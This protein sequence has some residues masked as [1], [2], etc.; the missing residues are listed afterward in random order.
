MNAV[1]AKPAKPIE[2]IRAQLNLPKMREQLQ[3]PLPRQVDL[4][5]FLRVAITAI[6]QNPDLLKQDRSSLYA[7]IMT[8]AQLGLLPDVQLGECYFIPR[9]GKVC[10]DPGYRGLIK[11]ARQGDIGHVEAELIYENDRTLYVLGDN[12]KLE[13]MVNWRDRGA[14]VGA[15]ALAKYRDGTICARGVRTT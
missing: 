2:L 13:I 4:D 9:K 1:T 15:Y 12:S 11:L 14:M 5:K 3:L 6:Q 8:A 7:A 10:C